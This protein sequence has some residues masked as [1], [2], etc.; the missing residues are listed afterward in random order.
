MKDLYFVGTSQDDMRGFPEDAKKMA[1]YQLHLVQSDIDPNDWKPMATV[2]Q[3]VKEIRIRESGNAYRVF[4][5]VVR[6]DGVYVLH[7]FQKTTQKTEKRDIELGKRRY[8]E[9]MRQK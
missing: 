8:R 9:V 6:N 2:G 4:Y 7:A 3:G 1:G 5:V